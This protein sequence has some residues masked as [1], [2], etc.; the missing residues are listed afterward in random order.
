MTSASCTVQ[1]HKHIHSFR[2]NDGATC[3]T[4]SLCW[5]SIHEHQPRSRSQRFLQGLDNSDLL[6]CFAYCYRRYG[7]RISYHEL[8]FCE[9]SF[10]RIVDVVLPICDCRAWIN[11]DL[12]S[13]WC[14]FGKHCPYTRIVEMDT[15]AFSISF[16][17]F[18]NVIVADVLSPCVVSYMPNPIKLLHL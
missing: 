1:I 15:S 12:D 7:G 17:A 9:C 11:T 5:R 14:G 8:K 2:L 10:R 6:G 18:A 13:F 4:T 3:Y 16:S